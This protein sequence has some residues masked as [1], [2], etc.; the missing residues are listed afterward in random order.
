MEPVLAFDLQR[1]VFGDLPPLFLLE[2]VVRVA[3]IWIWTITLLR[4]IGGR[5]ISQMSVV[6]FLLV[7]ALGSAVGDPMFQ[8]DVALLPAMLVILLVVLADKA[9]DLALWRWKGVKRL[10]DGQPTEL[11]RGGRILMGGAE[12]RRLSSSEIK[13]MLRLQSIRNLGQV[14]HAFLEPSGRVSVF[15]FDTPRPG[16][17]IL[18]LPVG[19]AGQSPP[20]GYPACCSCCGL[21]C[22]KPAAPCPHCGSVHWTSPE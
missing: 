13:E 19:D 16:L 9:V 7:I 15:L 17:R 8:P 21:V 11:V 22:A 3:V 20:P 14:D 12:A 5:S 6:E 1:M 2:I 10:V 4:W 18:P